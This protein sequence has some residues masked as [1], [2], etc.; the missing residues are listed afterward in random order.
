MGSTS[1]M[2]KNT[3][4]FDHYTTSY[5]W[6]VT[7]MTTVGYG[8]LTA[9]NIVEMVYAIVVMVVGKLV[10]GFILGTVA[11]TLA[12][13]ELERV[14][15]EDK[16]K[17]LKVCVMEVRVGCSCPSQILQTTGVRVYIQGM[18]AGSEII[19]EWAQDN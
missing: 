1:L 10:F 14:V 19:L 9:T 16:L 12:N 3:P 2:A 7:T 17:A 18:Q 15:F 4:I 13:M 5:Y 11:S 8:D 6:A